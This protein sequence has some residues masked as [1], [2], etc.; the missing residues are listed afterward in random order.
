MSQKIRKNVETKE[1][2]Q[3]VQSGASPS[4]K[5]KSMCDTKAGVREVA[6]VLWGSPE[7]CEWI[8]DFAH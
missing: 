6:R 1:I 3:Q 2:A 4:L 5:D 8:P 7:D